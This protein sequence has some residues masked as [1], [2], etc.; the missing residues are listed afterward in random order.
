M[1]SKLSLTQKISTT[2]AILLFTSGVVNYLQFHNVISELK[3]K[4]NEAIL[5][6]TASISDAISEEFSRRYSEVQDLAS[7]QVFRGNDL[8]SIS[9]TLDQ[10]VLTHSVYDLMMI[11]DLGGH[12]VALNSLTADGSTLHSNESEYPNFSAQEWFQKTI[13]GESTV[14]AP[15]FNA[16]IEKL[17]GKS[18]YTNQFVT[19]IKD[20]AGKSNRVL[21][22]FSNMK[23]LE[24]ILALRTQT[25]IKHEQSFSHLNLYLLARDG[26]LLSQFDGSSKDGSGFSHD[27]EILGKVNFVTNGNPAATALQKGESGQKQFSV[28]S[29]DSFLGYQPLVG[30]KALEEMKWGLV[31]DVPSSDMNSEIKK[32]EILNF[33]ITVGTLL[34]LFFGAVLYFKSIGRF[35]TL[36]LGSFSDVSD[37]ILKKSEELLNSSGDLS[38]A[39]SEQSSA[40]QESVSAL[41]EMS[42]MISQ[43]NENTK[44]SLV[45]TTNIVDQSIAGKEIMKKLGQSMSSIAES[46]ASLQEIAEIVSS[47]SQKT[48]VINEIV[49]KTQLLSFNA[50]IEA[51]RAGQYGKGFAVVAEEVGNLAQMSGDAAREIEVLIANSE[52]KVDSTLGLIQRRVKEGTVVSVEAV[53]AFNGIS[54][55]IE[56][57]KNQVKAIADA[58]VQQDVGIAQA[59]KAMSLLDEAA[60]RTSALANEMKVSSS[61]L[62][63]SSKKMSFNTFDMSK[64]V[65][66]QRSTKF[67]A[68]TKDNHSD[69]DLSI[70]SYSLDS[71]DTQHIEVNPSSHISADDDS[72]KSAA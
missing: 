63:E 52:K 66:G 37:V 24:S 35:L 36:K 7:F 41:A 5:V 39:N 3:R 2:G 62:E 44:S 47:I 61:T 20:E 10:F 67:K 68:K 48:S 43:T 69:G 34:L 42:S 32:L 27:S 40:I 57:I 54:S 70:A 22:A 50:S 11:T 17:Y 12:V 38:E 4:T 30:S 21:I 65:N 1:F 19:L 13:K 60:R 56:I 29:R 71:A 23:W 46:N 18:R 25:I 28:K 31:L 15:Q 14:V 58:T 9:K 33:F 45:S 8:R 53:N 49:F 16:W 26:T 51:A 55:A 64:L 72:F 59:Q 6:N